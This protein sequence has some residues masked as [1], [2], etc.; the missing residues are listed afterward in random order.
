MLKAIIDYIVN[1]LGTDRNVA[2]T[3]IFSLLTVIVA[4]LFT[5][6]AGLISKRKK[7]RGYKKSLRV[8]I[9]DFLKSCEKQYKEFEKFSEQKG[10]FYGE[11]YVISIAANYS[12]NYFEK[13]DISVFIENFYSLKKTRAEEIS[14]FFELIEKV[15][16]SKV[17]LRDTL[18]ICYEGYTKNLDLYNTNVDSLRRLHD[19]LSIRFD[20][21]PVDENFAN[22]LDSIVVI[23]KNWVDTGAVL[24]MQST[25][26]NLINPLFEQAKS[27]RPRNLLAQEIIEYCLKCRFAAEN[28][29]RYEALLKKTISESMEVHKTAY[30]RGKI[31]TSQ[32]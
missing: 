1:N 26:D 12:Q 21:H 14:E 13:L 3:I 11:D 29:K 19:N 7:R 9:R 5:W 28:M 2:V 31:I 22:Y 16:V 15:R 32:W 8:I 6:I 23:F 18:A 17:Y 27:S 25:L 24:N 30:S 4:Q 10:Y 20:G